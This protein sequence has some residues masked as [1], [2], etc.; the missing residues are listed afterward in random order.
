MI[1]VLFGR[2]CR[3]RF[4]IPCIHAHVTSIYIKH[5]P[6]I[7]S[8]HFLRTYV[9]VFTLLL[10]GSA[11]NLRAA[12]A[13]RC[14]ISTQYEH[15]LAVCSIL[16]RTAHKC[17]LP[18]CSQVFVLHGAS[19]SKVTV[20]AQLLKQRAESCSCIIA[21]LDPDVAGRQSRTVIDACLP[22]RCWHAFLPVWQATAAEDIRCVTLLTP[23]LPPL[24][25]A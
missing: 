13:T 15:A 21:L 4:A 19:K 17:P 1:S 16:H 24:L 7:F 25:L 22:G 6:K 3:P 5:E 9:H 8:V 2:L 11:A 18:C 20:T 10:G 23:L 14:A 12:V